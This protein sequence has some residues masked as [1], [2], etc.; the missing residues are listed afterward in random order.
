MMSPWVHGGYVVP[1]LVAWRV[2][3][4]FLCMFVG[5]LYVFRYLGTDVL[6]K[7]VN[8]ANAEKHLEPRDATT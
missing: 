4:L 6:E 1:Y 8:E 5:G 3:T 7:R 2:L